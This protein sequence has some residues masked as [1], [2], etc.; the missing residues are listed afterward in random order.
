MRERERERERKREPDRAGRT[1]IFI[2]PAITVSVT[3]TVNLFECPK[4]QRPRG[5]PPDIW[6]SR[7]HLELPYMHSRNAQSSSG[8]NTLLA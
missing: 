8:L 5:P 6:L 3:E 1:A 4:N 7:L 2:H